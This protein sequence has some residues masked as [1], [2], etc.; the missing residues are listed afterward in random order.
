[1]RKS[2][3]HGIAPPSKKLILASVLLSVLSVQAYALSGDNIK[4]KHP[5]VLKSTLATPTYVSGFAPAQITTA[6]NFTSISNQG[7]GQVI[8]LVDAFDDPNAE[9][10]L[11]VFSSNFNLPACTT[12][13]GCFQKIYASGTK[14]TG[15]TGWGI[16]ISL[17]VQWAHAIAP[18]AKIILVEAASN[19]FSDL[20]QAINVAIQKGATVV[21]MSW[22][23]DEFVGEN[24]YDSTFN[25][26]DVTFT[27][28]SGDGGHNIWYPAVSPNVIG[29][30]GTTLSV[31]A[32]GKYL[33]ES[34]WSGSGGGISTVETEPSYQLNL[35]IPNNPNKFRGAPDV[36]YNANPNTGFAVYDSYG[37]GGWLIIGGTSAG[38]PQWAA[39]IA[40]AKSSASTQLTGINATLY[41]LA[42]SNYSTDFHDITSGSNGSCGTICDAEVGYDYVTGIGTPQAGALIAAI[43]GT[44][45]PPPPPPPPPQEPAQQLQNDFHKTRLGTYATCTATA[46][47]VTC[48]VPA[49]TQA[50]SNSEPDSVLDTMVTENLAT[51]QK[52]VIAVNPTDYSKLTCQLQSG[53]MEIINNSSTTKYAVF[54]GLCEDPLP[55]PFKK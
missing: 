42:K 18:K 7:E 31:N 9:A 40:I 35:P 12:A 32:A 1:M 49:S 26:P 19:S 37:Y 38:S 39:L 23:G 3:N 43:A 53:S 52:D 8:A 34:A 21:S 10:D 55:F 16:E 5:Y 41:T 24:S 14:P 2:W 29:V 30:G 44:T 11:G 17:D 20:F 22:G 54:S 36:S 48:I 4:A 33:S 45:P 46:S 6:Y 13:N 50:I 47:L 28:A 15:D 25:V 27:A 51:M